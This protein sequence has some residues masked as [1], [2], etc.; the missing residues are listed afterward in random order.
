MEII[1]ALGEKVKNL[2]EGS[3]FG[4]LLPTRAHFFVRSISGV[5]VCTNPDC[6]RHKGYRLPIGSLTTYQNIN[7]P[8]CK[9]KML[10]LAT[11]SSC[12]S[13]IVV[14]ETSTTKGF[15]MH[16]NIIDLDNTLFYEQKEDL[17]DSEDMENIE[18]VEQN[19]AD[20]FS[21]FFFAI[22]EKLCLRKMRL[23]LL[24]FSI[25]GMAK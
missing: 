13:P 9:S 18:N 5:Y 1:D 4:A 23:V 19:E 12:G 15:R 25:I 22:P 7:C 2:N 10:E 11:C 14:G 17:I 8:V 16:T 21:R 3:G 20:G 6:Q 24:T